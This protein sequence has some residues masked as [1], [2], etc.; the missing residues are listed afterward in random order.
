MENVFIV[1]IKIVSV[2]LLITSA[3]MLIQNIYAAIISLWGYGKVERDYEILE[4]KTRFL[5]LVAA[6]N[7]EDVIADT[8]SNL[9]KIDYDENLY[10]IYVVNDN[11][12]DRTGEICKEIGIPHVD[13]IEGKF[14]REGVG[15]PAG[16][17]Y[18]LRELGFEK[19]QE[20]YDLLMILDADNYVDSNILKDLNS[21]WQQKGKPEAIQTYLDSKNTTSILAT[22]YACAYWVTNRFF[23]LAKY[24]LGLPNA[25]GGTGFAVRLDWLFEHGGFSYKSL[26]EDLEMEIEIV[27]SHG[28]ILW[29]HHARIYDEKPD[30]LKVSIRQRTRWSQGHWYVAFNNFKNLSTA[31]IKERK[32]KYID[33]LLYL[34]GMG[35]GVQLLLAGISLL[36]LTIYY[37]ASR[38]GFS[39]IVNAFGVFF[40]QLFVP[41]TI[42]NIVFL[43]YTLII[44]LVYALVKDG[45]ERN[46]LKAILAMLYFGTTYMYTQL[47]GLLKWRQQ[48]VW[49]KTPHKHTKK[50]II[51]E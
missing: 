6:H 25:I 4:D 49:V 16:L 11:S 40:M 3:Y 38:A 8:V 37:I 45:R 27:K 9:R 20:K 18:A 5:I 50:E 10:D 41:T 42:F 14:A 44:T 32:F 47:V 36:I 23:Q 43:V 31:F 26:T 15:K 29:N 34:F 1:L 13:T 19:L 2:C 28:R 46:F 21:Q 7:E 39:L 22:G 30:G 24:R 35:K 51:R 48:G 12:T 17:Q 33:Q